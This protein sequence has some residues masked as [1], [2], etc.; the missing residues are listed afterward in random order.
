LAGAPPA[1]LLASGS[2][3]GDL[4]IGPALVA[5]AVIAVGFQWSNDV[6]LTPRNLSNLCLQL[7]TLGTLTI[8]L[9]PVLLIGEVDLSVG[10]VAGLCASVMAVLSASFGQSAALSIAAAVAVGGL[11]GLAQGFWI[12]VV[13]AP[14]FIVTLTGLLVWQGTQRLL[15]GDEVG[16]LEVEDR[17]IR[18]I[19]STYMPASLAWGTVAMIAGIAALA[20]VQVGSR[21]GPLRRRVGRCAPAMAYPLVASAV[22]ITLQQYFGVPY[23]L[24]MLAVLA[25]LLTVL[26][27]RTPLGVHIFAV[28]GNA[29]A[30]R[31]MGINVTGLRIAVFALSS[32]LAALGGVVSASRQFSVDSSTGGG[33]LVLD[34]IA[35]SVI[36]GTSLFGGRGRVVG[37]LLGAVAIASVANGLDLLGQTADV[38]SIITGLILLA[39][40]SVDTRARFRRAASRPAGT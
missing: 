9:V 8:G 7:G 12:A 40:V 5:L 10:S 38:K 36:G 30:A 14:S 24:L 20:C 3:D 4:G 32:A 33:N 16:A 19:A 27:E 26:T 6:F 17:F 39:S 13:Q 21:H 25:A 11:I 18:G 37:G 22:V 2:G 34:A 23:L 29:E 35:A 28:G 15:L 1:P 31:V